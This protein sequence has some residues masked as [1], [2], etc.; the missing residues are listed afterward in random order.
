LN[1]SSAFNRL[2]QLNVLIDDGGNAVLCDF[3]LSRIKADATSRTAKVEAGGVVGSRNWMAP[4]RLMGGALKKPCDIYAFGMTM[5]EVSTCYLLLTVVNPMQLNRQI[6]ANETPLSDLSFVEFLELVVRQD[7]RPE[8]PD[9]ED[10]PYLSDEI[11]E[12]AEKCWVKEPKHRPTA[13]AV[14]DTLSHL[15]DIMHIVPSS[16]LIAQVKPSPCLLGP[17]PNLTMRGHTDKV[18]CA[19]FS[20]DGK[21]IVSG[22]KDRTVRVWDAQ[23]GNLTLGPLR[24][25]THSVWCVAFSPNSRQIASGSKDNSILVWDALT[26]ETVA[27]PF[28]GHTSMVR[29]VSFSPDS[30]KIIS[31]SYDKT[32]QIWDARTGANVVGPLKGHT[33][34]IYCVV[35]SGDGKQVASGSWDK[36]IRVWD[37]ETGRLVLEPLKGHK[38]YVYFVAFS[39]DGSRIVSASYDGDVCVW[40]KGTGALMSGPSL[41]HTEGTLTVAFTPNST[42]WWTVS[43]NG[44]WIARPSGDNGRAVR[45]WDSKTGLLVATLWD[46]TND[47]WSVSFSPDSKKV[48]AACWDKTVRVHTINW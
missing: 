7:V 22:S 12:L 41:Q 23:T 36:T 3:G 13:S 28:K 38:T 32:V 31:G 24:M 34:H 29:S 2:L 42:W 33:N 9:D 19:T 20:P 11:W 1:I 30:S 14:C 43:P 10:A 6:Y 27:G 37:A 4:E 25:H 44:R 8:Q 26:G 48:L 21:C 39:R 17:S 47:V 16:L 40:D 35:F 5:Y 45:V 18:Y 15:L 46:D